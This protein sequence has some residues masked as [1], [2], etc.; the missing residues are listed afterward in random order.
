MDFQYTLSFIY[1]FMILRFQWTV[2]AFLNVCGGGRGGLLYNFHKESFTNI[3]KVSF[4]ELFHPFSPNVEYIA[5]A[6]IFSS[7]ILT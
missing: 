4:L 6:G 1:S 5:T 3:S 7:E 2:K